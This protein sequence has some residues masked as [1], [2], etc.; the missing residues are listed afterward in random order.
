[1]YSM[2]TEVRNKS[3]LHAR[4]AS[5]FT[6]KAREFSSDITIRNLDAADA[7][8]LNAKSVLKV[9]AEKL[10]LGTKVEISAQGADERQAVECLV[11]L[12]E[13]GL[14]EEI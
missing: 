3:G 2:T 14:G 1:M 11:A 4:P 5:N 6:M 12:V 9:M 8:A 7:R 13:A 10:K